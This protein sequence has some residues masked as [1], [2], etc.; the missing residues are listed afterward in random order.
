MIV[1]KL[2]VID[3]I[4]YDALYALYKQGFIGTDRFPENIPYK[5]VGTDGTNLELIEELLSLDMDNM[6]HVDKNENGLY[7]ITQIGFI[8]NKKFNEPVSEYQFTFGVDGRWEDVWQIGNE[9]T[10]DG[11]IFGELKIYGN[12]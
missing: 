9:N 5:L 10:L 2:N 1:E 12:L 11:S 4:S 7:R 6:Y 8:I 3:V